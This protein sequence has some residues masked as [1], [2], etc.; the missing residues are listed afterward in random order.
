ML[1]RAELGVDFAFMALGAVAE[2]GTLSTANAC[3]PVIRRALQ[4]NVFRRATIKDIRIL[5]E[6]GKTL[7]AAF[8]EATGGSG[9][10][11]MLGTAIPALNSSV[12]LMRL[13]ADQASG[14]GVIWDLDDRTHLMAVVNTSALLFD[15]LPPAL[16]DSSGA[17]IFLRNQRQPVAA[18]TPVAGAPSDHASKTFTAGSERFPL[19]ASIKVDQIA[20]ARWNQEP[21]NLLLILAGL[22]GLAFG[23]LGVKVL[24]REPHPIAAIDKALAA[25]EYHPYFQPIFDLATQEIVACEV[26]ARWVKS[27][28]NVVPPYRFIPL[29]EQ[30]GRI[31]PMTW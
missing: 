19:T 29:A 20:L 13:P 17:R 3:S 26:L 31:V 23:I 18:F 14:L 28:G 30:S 6:S 25:R 4:R 7:C 11:A 9:Y 24:F 1:R 8:P 10:R 2:S 12:R 15:I 16:R 21:H 27:D 22:L 5:N